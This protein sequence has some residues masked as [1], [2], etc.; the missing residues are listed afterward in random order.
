MTWCVLTNDVRLSVM[1]DISPKVARTLA[2]YLVALAA[3]LE[4]SDQDIRATR[5]LQSFEQALSDLSIEERLELIRLSL[6]LS[7]QLAVRVRS[8]R[9]PLTSGH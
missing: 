5:N 9:G 7:A 3:R 6:L 1:A 4:A 8:L 2:R